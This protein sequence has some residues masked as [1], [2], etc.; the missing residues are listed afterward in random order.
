MP[1]LTLY[2]IWHR[3]HPVTSIHTDTTHQPTTHPPTY[4]QFGMI[5]LGITLRFAYICYIISADPIIVS[6]HASVCSGADKNSGRNINLISVERC[7]ALAVV[8]LNNC[9]PRNRRVY[10]HIYGR[11][12]ICAKPRLN[13]NPPPPPTAAKQYD[14][15]AHVR[16][17]RALVRGAS[18]V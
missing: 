14:I 15:H 13:A 1:Y 5:C 3:C 12:V 9:Q 16:A 17:H 8:A 4:K 7:G 6:G 2:P 10:P 18:F 11:H